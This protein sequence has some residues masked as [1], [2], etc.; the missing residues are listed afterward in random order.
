M[1]HRPG[2]YFVIAVNR[3]AQ[4]ILVNRDFA[5]GRGRAVSLTEARENARQPEYEGQE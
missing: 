5:G 4:K 1:A 3:R 2:L